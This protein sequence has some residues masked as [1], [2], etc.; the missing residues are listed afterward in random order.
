MGLRAGG[1][2]VSPQVLLKRGRIDSKVSREVKHFERV[3]E[4]KT[5]KR[6]E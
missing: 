6:Q 1:G 5:F 3:T 2:G 4:V